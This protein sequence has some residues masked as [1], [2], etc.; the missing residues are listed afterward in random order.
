MNNPP[1]S[2]EELALPKVEAKYLPFWEEKSRALCIKDNPSMRGFGKPLKIGDEVV[3]KG[4]VFDI[5]HH[6]ILSV[7]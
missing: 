4:V 7:M 1:T 2:R 3:V 5:I 6:V